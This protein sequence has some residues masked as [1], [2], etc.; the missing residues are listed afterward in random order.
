MVLR[1]EI[2][3]NNGIHM[4]TN[5]AHLTKL[6]V[7]NNMYQNDQKRAKNYKYNLSMEMK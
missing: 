3:L 6:Q 4:Q 7:K 2:T 1:D 5:N